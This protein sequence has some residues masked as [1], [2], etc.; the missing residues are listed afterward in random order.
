MLDSLFAN[1]YIEVAYSG[2]YYLSETYSQLKSLIEDDNSTIT[3]HVYDLCGIFTD[4][5]TLSIW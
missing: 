2:T 3:V 5:K 1:S 4:E